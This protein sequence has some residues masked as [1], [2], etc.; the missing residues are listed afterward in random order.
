MKLNEKLVS[1]RR[2][3]GMSQAELAE[4]LNV[5]RQA[6]SKWEQGTAALSTDNLIRL[7]ALYGVSLDYLVYDK[8]QTEIADASR[9]EVHKKNYDFW[10]GFMLALVMA[11]IVVISV[12]V[13]PRF[14]QGG[15]ELETIIQKDLKQE[16]GI[17]IS[18]AGH[19]DI[20]W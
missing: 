15:E 7:S 5:S 17:D 12:L 1:L 11:A 8:E 14:T 3:N 16:G 6:I 20:V 19:F 2:K 18:S 13:Y 10:L 4:K 9:T